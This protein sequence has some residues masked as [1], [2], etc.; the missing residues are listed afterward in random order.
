[1]NL[2]IHLSAF[3]EFFSGFLCLEAFFQVN[4]FS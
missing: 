3:D 2:L 4:L 1:M